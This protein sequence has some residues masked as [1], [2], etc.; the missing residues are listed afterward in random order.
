MTG[1]SALS[2]PEL[3][4]RKN[5]NVL[6]EPFLRITGVGNAPGTSDGF[7]CAGCREESR[8]LPKKAERQMHI[9]MCSPMETSL[10]A[11]L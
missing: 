5:A 11:K 2:G 3:T 7:Y 6:A 4:G 8:H 9:T 10:E 1:H